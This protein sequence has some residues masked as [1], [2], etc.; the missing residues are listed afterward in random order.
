MNAPDTALALALIAALARDPSLIWRLGIDRHTLRRVL[1]EDAGPPRA[2]AAPAPPPAPDLR[3]AA[4]DL[5]LTLIAGAALS[6]PDAARLLGR[7][8]GTLRRWRC[9]GRGPAAR[10]GPGGRWLYDLA[11][12]ENFLRHDDMAQD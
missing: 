2:A 11:A 8:A 12:L 3:A 7:S 6:E 4:R 1:G 9:E 10:R 5:G